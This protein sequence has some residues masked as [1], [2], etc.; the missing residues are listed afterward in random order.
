MNGHAWLEPDEQLKMCVM[1]K[2]C[3]LLKHSPRGDLRLKDGSTTDLYFD[4]RQHRGSAKATEFLARAFSRS[5]LDLDVKRFVEIPQALS[6]LAGVITVMTGIP[7]V[8]VREEPKK[9]REYDEW[10]IGPFEK[11]D[12]VCVIDDVVSTGRTKVPAIKRCVE[13]G[14]NVVA[15]VVLIERTKEWHDT[16]RENDL[17]VLVWPGMTISDVRRHLTTLTV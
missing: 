17:D 9:G 15:V 6:S 14:L 7:F 5:I 12:K 8:T 1:M 13:A 2:E 4:L 16:F 3:G 10:F 11:G